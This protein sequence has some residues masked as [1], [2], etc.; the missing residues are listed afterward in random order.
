MRTALHHLMPLFTGIERIT[1]NLHLFQFI[2]YQFLEQLTSA[3]LLDLP[4][5]NEEEIAKPLVRWLCTERS[6]KEA[7][8]V[9]LDRIDKPNYIID[10]IRK[11]T[12]GRELGK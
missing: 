10:E 7:R 5:A 12:L 11:V 2:M 8:I 3:K 1:F 4:E 9:N 6:D